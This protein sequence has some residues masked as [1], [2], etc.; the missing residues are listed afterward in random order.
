VLLKQIGASGNNPSV[1]HD[2]M[3]QAIHDAACHL[4]AQ[5]AN[6]IE[7]D[8]GEADGANKSYISAKYVG[9]GGG[10]V[11]GCVST[12]PIPIEFE[13]K[14]STSKEAG[15]PQES[16]E[17]PT[18]PTA[19]K[20]AGTADQSADDAVKAKTAARARAL[21]YLIKRASQQIG[22]S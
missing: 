2:D 15:L 19:D 21:A 20:A 12:T 16:T 11:G 7:A 18:A 3:V 22:E 9:G 10:G 14:S 4:G 17:E 5:C 8:S 6:E 1:K 13:E